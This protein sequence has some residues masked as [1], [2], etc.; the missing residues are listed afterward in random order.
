MAQRKRKTSPSTPTLPPQLAAAN[1]HA[2]GIDIGAEGHFVA[3]PPSD[4]PQPVRGFG[5]Y[6]ADLEALEDWLD[7]LPPGVSAV[8][9]N[10]DYV[11]AE[12]TAARGDSVTA[13]RLYDT[14]AARYA[15]RNDTY[16]ASRSMLA[17]SAAAAAR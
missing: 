9:P 13:A 16:G 3:V 2:A 10:F 15:D 7:R 17:A 14:A 4:D 8:Y 6:T 12:M 1:L 5:A 11:R